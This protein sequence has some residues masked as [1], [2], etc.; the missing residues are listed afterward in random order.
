VATYY[1]RRD[2]L[3]DGITDADA[4]RFARAL[5]DALDH[6]VEWANHSGCN[7]EERADREDHRYEAQRVFESGA[8]WYR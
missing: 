4:Q 1:V 5:A 2:T 8:W 7:C 3:G 6:D